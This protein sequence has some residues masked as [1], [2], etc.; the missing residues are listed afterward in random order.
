MTEPTDP[1]PRDRRRTT[2]RVVTWNIRFG[3]E[4][5]RAMDVLDSEP[6][7]A[8]LDLLLLQEM[9]E[10]GTAA[11]ADRMGLEHVY[12]SSGIHAQS[13]RHFG[14]AVLSRHPIAELP[15]TPLPYR[16]KVRGQDRVVARAVVEIVGHRIE[17][18]SVHTE[19][20]TLEPS[21]R[22]AQFDRTAASFGDGRGRPSIVGG[23]FNTMTRRGRAAL[24]AAFGDR[25]FV[26]ASE[27]AGP[28]LRQAR[29]AFELDHVFTRGFE[30]IEV[31]VTAHGDAS[32]HHPVRVDLA[33]LDAD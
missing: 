7:L 23:D 20:P 6:A 9:D 16:S 17:V 15:S 26:R 24:D 27:G 13:G 21:R 33:A 32:D 4:V 5:D 29:G 12:A 2:V 10:E 25:G 28:T 8:D 11:I 1:H 30:A 14:N 31:A 3:V 19:V 18:G 22:R